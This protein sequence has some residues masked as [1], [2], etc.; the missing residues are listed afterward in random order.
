MISLILSSSTE[1]T[2]TLT[3][4]GLEPNK[5]YYKYEDSYKNGIEILTDKDGSYTFVQDL[6]KPHHVWFQ[7]KKG[8][9]F[10]PDDCTK[11]GDWNP[12]NRTC[13]LTQDLT[14]S[15]EINTSSI[16]LD[17]NGHSITGNG[18][19]YGIYLHQKNNTT[20]ENCIIINFSTGIELYHFPFDFE[21]FTKNNNLSNNVIFGNSLG[22]HLFY[23]DHN[24]LIDNNVH[25]NREG[26]FL[27]FSSGNTLHNNKM[28][29]NQYNFGVYDPCF[30]N[31]IDTSNTVDGRPIYYI[32]NGANMVYDGSTNAGTFH[33]IN[34]N[35]VIV[36]D[37]HVD[38]NY[39]GIRF[40]N[41]KNSEIRNVTAL[42]N[43]FGIHLT[44]Y[45]NKNKI[46][47]NTAL[48]NEIG[49]WLSVSNEN[50]IVDNIV[51]NNGGG[52][53]S[54]WISMGN[55]ITKNLLSNNGIGIH[56]FCVYYNEVF[57]NNLV[58]NGTGILL[59]ICVPYLNAKV[60]HNNFIN[61]NY[62]GRIYPFTYPE[63]SSLYVFDNGYPEGGNYWSDYDTSEEGCNDKDKDGFCDTPYTF[64]G[65]Q[66]RYP[67]MKENGWL[68]QKNKPPI[69]VIN[70][71]PKNPVKGVKVK[72]D[73]SSSTDP[74]G[75]IKEFFWEIKREEEILATST[76]TTTNFAF[77]EN[78]DYRITL[79]ATDNDGATSSTST[80]IKVEPFSF[81]IIT[82]LHIGRGYPDYDG[83]GFDDGYNGEEYYLTQRL[84]NVVNWINAHKENY[85]FKFVA[86]LGDIAD[87]AEKSEFCKAKEILD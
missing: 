42:N 31:Y 40:C 21:A 87:T 22:I 25:S 83:E 3:L 60:Y 16:T 39:S 29:D 61:N 9:I 76:V 78:G 58:N 64:E 6:T 19:G 74:D 35:N 85:S 44:S 8:T 11:Y 67:F 18:G 27:D 52:I 63:D 54:D 79:I 23:A 7:E 28:T 62:Q 80:T 20:I 10:L 73:A 26:I 48:N 30:P 1:A 2:T 12:E 41:T 84:R 32:L 17:C 57:E 69:P 45:S 46:T 65:G 71:F 5:K 33:C 72:F 66:D 75:E 68:L 13:T 59:Q 34:C 15:V 37:L 36:K 38:K 56:L 70:F 55:I 4:K 14:E 50:T 43:R 49:I 77:S 47:G 53:W 86:V 81:A 82:D 51:L 24:T